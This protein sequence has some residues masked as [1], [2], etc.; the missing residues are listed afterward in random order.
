MKNTIK[1]SIISACMGFSL[2]SSASDITITESFP[3]QN[4]HMALRG[5]MIYME[6]DFPQGQNPGTFTLT[7][8]NLDEYCGLPVYGS[9]CQLNLYNLN[10]NQLYNFVLITTDDQGAPVRVFCNPQ[11]TTLATCSSDGLHAIFTSPQASTNR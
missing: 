7:K 6:Y 9:N 1:Y 5:H 10:N 2:I 8:D 4:N 11:K 3:L